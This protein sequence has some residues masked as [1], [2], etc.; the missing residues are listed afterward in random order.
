M[1][2]MKPVEELAGRQEDKSISTHLYEFLLQVVMLLQPL[3]QFVR[4]GS[5]RV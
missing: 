4:A 1:H 2:P 3:Q 5:T